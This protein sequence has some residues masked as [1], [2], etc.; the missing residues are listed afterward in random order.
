MSTIS[1]RWGSGGKIHSFWAMYSLRMSFCSV[2][3]SRPPVDPL[4]LGGDQQ[5]REQHL[6]GAVD[7]HRHRDVAERDPGEE[8]DHVLAGADR[9]PAVADL[10]EGSVVVGVEPHQGGHVERHREP[11]LALGERGSGN[12]RWCRPP[13]RTRRTGASS[14]ACPGNR[15]GGCRGCTGRRPGNRSTRPA[16]PRRVA[17]G[18]DVL[19]GHRGEPVLAVPPLGV[20]PLPVARPSASGGAVTASLPRRI[21]GCSQRSMTRRVSSGPTGSPTAPMAARYPA[22]RSSTSMIMSPSYGWPSATARRWAYSAASRPP[23]T[24]T[25]SVGAQVGVLHVAHLPGQDPPH[26]L[27]PQSRAV[28]RGQVGR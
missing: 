8:V 4:L 13:R 25:S 18:G 9:D 7:R 16:R 14:T 1:R 20:A 19:E 15:R 22:C 5:E 23:T 17:Q 10:A 24:T 26:V 3:R 12:A 28:A 21:S 27:S 2:P 6:G 11:V